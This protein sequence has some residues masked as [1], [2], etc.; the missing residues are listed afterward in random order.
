M[1]AH[2][3]EWLAHQDR[4]TAKT[5]PIPIPPRVVSFDICFSFSGCGFY[6][7][8]KFTISFTV[9]FINHFVDRNRYEEYNKLHI[10]ISKEQYEKI[11][12][13]SHSLLLFQE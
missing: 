8:F 12:L 4:T 6:L 7:L 11:H 9:I 10:A 1:I 13:T 5:T 2:R 3:T